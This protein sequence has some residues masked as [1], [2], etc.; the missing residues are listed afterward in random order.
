MIAL[1]IILAIVIIV[2]GIVALW[3]DD[4]DNPTR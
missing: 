2:L 1:V 4:P 3:H